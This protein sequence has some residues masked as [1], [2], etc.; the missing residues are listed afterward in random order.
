MYT[1]S[2]VMVNGYV[3]EKFRVT[4][5]VRQG[6]PLS[7]YL[8]V[9]TSEIMAH[10]FR[11]TNSLTGIPMAGINNRVTKYA[12]DT[13]LF[14]SKWEEVRVTE[15]HFRLFQRASGSR[16]KNAKTQILRLGPLKNVQPPPEYRNYVVEKLKL[17]GVYF[18]SHGWIK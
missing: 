3:S 17:Y 8:Y 14:L 10:Y 1:S 4:R 16:L 12:D 11:K 5:G 15:Q 6:C 7:P 9:I 2:S 18:D 13:S